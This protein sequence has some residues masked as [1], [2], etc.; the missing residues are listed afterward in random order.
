M[1]K[2]L[3]S[4]QFHFIDKQ[5]KREES[6]QTVENVIKLLSRIQKM[7]DTQHEI[8]RIIAMIYQRKEDYKEIKLDLNRCITEKKQDDIKLEDINKDSLLRLY[9]MLV[10]LSSKIR[11]GIQGLKSLEKTMNRPFVFEGIEYDGDYMHKQLKRLRLKICKTFPFISDTAQMETFF[12][13]DGNISEVRKLRKK[14]YLFG[15]DDKDALSSEEE[16]GELGDDGDVNYVTH[17]ISMFSTQER[18]L[19]DRSDLLNRSIA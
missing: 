15:K 3:L 5:Y 9:P 12:T 8:T 18:G 14:E 13:K 4:R 17:N 7:H 10:R 19:Y 16:E 11:V 1:M 2:L 6:E